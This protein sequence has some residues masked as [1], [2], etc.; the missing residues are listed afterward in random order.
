MLIVIC[1]SHLIAHCPEKL[2][3][4]S[5]KFQS[6]A[7]SVYTNR[8]TH[9]GTKRLLI[10][11]LIGNVIGCSQFIDANNKES[12]TR[13]MCKKLMNIHTASVLAVPLLTTVRASSH[14]TDSGSTAV[15][16]QGE[17]FAYTVQ[18]I[19][20]SNNLCL[21]DKYLQRSETVVKTNEIKL[22]T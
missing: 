15:R 16:S 5:N 10:T 22:I 8:A 19:H 18:L 14:W 1:A 20:D 13:R 6:A 7:L 12:H 11:L 2:N 17:T 3:T 21:V 4:H 9:C